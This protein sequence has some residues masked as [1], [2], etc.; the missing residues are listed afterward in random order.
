[1]HWRK[2]VGIEEASSDSVSAYSQGR[3]CNSSC[4]VGNCLQVDIHLNETGV[5]PRVFLP[6]NLVFKTRWAQANG[7]LG[8]GACLCLKSLW[9]VQAITG[10]KCKG[11]FLRNTCTGSWLQCL[12][13]LQ[14]PRLCTHYEYHLKLKGQCST[15]QHIHHALWVSNRHCVFFLIWPKAFSVLNESEKTAKYA[16][17]QNTELQINIHKIKHV[18]TKNKWAFIEFILYRPSYGRITNSYNGSLNIL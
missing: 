4:A 6:A 11:V 9:N 3:G 18:L 10:H 5:E 17:T 8:N 16:F 14:F 15:C 7:I 2:E 1:M 12:H 13:V